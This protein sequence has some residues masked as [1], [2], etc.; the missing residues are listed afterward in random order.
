MKTSPQL[1]KKEYGND[2]SPV[3]PSIHPPERSKIDEQSNIDSSPETIHTK[4]SKAFGNHSESKRSTEN[5]V[6]DKR[7]LKQPH[8]HA[9][10]SSGAESI[11]LPETFYQAVM[12]LSSKDWRSRIDALQQIETMAEKLKSASDRDLLNVMDQLTYR[13]TD[14]NSKVV[15]VTFEVRWMY[16][17]NAL[18]AFRL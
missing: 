2:L 8:R 18:F 10:R 6:S 15:L 5:D 17:M 11:H 9:S 3:T 12:D 16:K 4:Y 13:L 14:G 1:S 7:L